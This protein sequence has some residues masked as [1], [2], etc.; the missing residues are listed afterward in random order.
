MSNGKLVLVLSGFKSMCSSPLQR[1]HVIHPQFFFPPIGPLQFSFNYSHFP[2]SLR[3][4]DHSTLQSI[5]FLLR[6]WLSLSPA[7]S[8]ILS[9]CPPHPHP[10]TLPI[11][12]LYLVKIWDWSTFKNFAFTLILIPAPSELNL[13]F[14]SLKNPQTLPL[15]TNLLFFL[16]KRGP[17]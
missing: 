11:P 13:I 17:W 14:S 3:L 10:T 5:L 4:W 1:Y 12:L 16:F 6:D 8:L 7:W 2:D 15:E 9:F